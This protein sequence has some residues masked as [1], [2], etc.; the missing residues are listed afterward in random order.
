MKLTL[1]PPHQNIVTLQVPLGGRGVHG[2]ILHPSTHRSPIP[3]LV[4]LIRA[5][6][7]ICT[8]DALT[9]ASRSR[10]ISPEIKR[11]IDAVIVDSLSRLRVV[12]FKPRT[13]SMLLALMTMLH[14]P[15]LHLSPGSWVKG[16]H[17]MDILVIDG[18]GDGFWPER[19]TEE[20]RSGG[21]RPKQGVKDAEDLGMRDI[22]SL[23]EDI[24]K[25]LGTV[26]VLS[27]QGLWVSL[28]LIPKLCAR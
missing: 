19:W 21:R 20:G 15:S 4:R 18:F 27:I 28:G 14:P 6:V 24:R 3:A 7:T 1:P 11:N 22:V 12:K 26:I 25:E 16:D 10:V 17:A 5:H 9:A 23:V 8:Q 13:K 2:G